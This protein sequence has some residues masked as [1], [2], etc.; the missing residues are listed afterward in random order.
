MNECSCTTLPDILY[1]KYKPSIL[2][3]YTKRVSFWKSEIMVEQ[4]DALMDGELV[5]EK[6][7]KWLE[8][9]LKTDK[10]LRESWLWTHHFGSP[11]GCRHGIDSQGSAQI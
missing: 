10:T 8:Q 1:E 7:N 5:I 3:V 6:A 2:F 9:K 4:M 11:P